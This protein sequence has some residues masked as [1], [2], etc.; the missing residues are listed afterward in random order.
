MSRDPDAIYE[1]GGLDIHIYELDDGTIT[2]HT[3]PPAW[4]AEYYD[5]KGVW[6]GQISK[7]IL[8]YRRENE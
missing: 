4:G 3:N 1:Y 2:W 7:A 6:G 8:K 5:E